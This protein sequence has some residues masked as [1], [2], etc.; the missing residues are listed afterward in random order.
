MKKVSISFSNKQ[1]G[2][3]GAWIA[4]WNGTCIPPNKLPLPDQPTRKR[5]MKRTNVVSEESHQPFIFH[6]DKQRE[7]RLRREEFTR[8]FITGFVPLSRAGREE[9]GG[10]YANWPNEKRRISSLPPPPRLV[11]TSIQLH[12][13]VRPVIGDR[14]PDPPLIGGRRIIVIMFSRDFAWI[15]YGHCSVARASKAFRNPEPG[16]AG[17]P[18]ESAKCIRTLELHL[19]IAL[20]AGRCR[21]E[22]GISDSIRKPCAVH[23]DSAQPTKRLCGNV[24]CCRCCG[25]EIIRASELE[26]FRATKL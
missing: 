11:S 13:N 2:K 17:I 15:Y 5:A 4:R 24:R 8:S 3:K 25:G 16:R 7:H 12:N 10:N 6:R 21:G 18:L 22:G 26:R 1:T 9:G 14:G 20:L 19:T 23:D